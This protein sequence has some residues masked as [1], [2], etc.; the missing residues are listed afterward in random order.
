M[1]GR[2]VV[3]APRHDCCRWAG[4]CGLAPHDVQR[5]MRASVKITM[6]DLA[7]H[8]MQAAASAVR[9]PSDLFAAVLRPV[10][11]PWVFGP[12][13]DGPRSLRANIRYWAD[14]D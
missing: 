3:A 8:V 11:S 9:P 5:N 1:E 2:P 13:P 6:C 12:V 14:F 4:T 7:P 10:L